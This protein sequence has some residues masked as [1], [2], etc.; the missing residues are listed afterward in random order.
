MNMHQRNPPKS[1]ANHREGSG[2]FGQGLT[3]EQ[4]RIECLPDIAILI[5]DRQVMNGRQPLVRE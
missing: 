4:Q 3:G 5:I 1:I 2:R